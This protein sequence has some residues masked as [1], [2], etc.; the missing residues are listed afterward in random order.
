MMRLGISEAEAKLYIALFKG[1]ELSAMEIH[2]L[3]KVPRT[4]VC[5]IT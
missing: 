5:E 2:E 3:T 4:K 1:G